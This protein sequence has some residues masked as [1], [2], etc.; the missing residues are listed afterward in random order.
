MPKISIVLPTYNG[1]KWIADAIQSIVNQSFG[2]WELLVIDDGSTDGTY[3]IVLDFCK[4]DS[5][6]LYIKNEQNLGLQ[7]TLNKGINLTKGEYIARIDDDDRWSDADKLKKQVEFLDLNSDCVLIG[8]GVVVVDDFDRE[9]L[10][11]LNPETDK[12]IRSTILKR[13]PFVH[14]SVVFRKDAGIKAGLYDE[15]DYGKHI[16]DYEFWF[17]LGREGKMYNLPIYAVRFMSR[18]GNTTN[19]NRS[20]QLFKAIR[21][22]KDNRKYY[23]G[24]LKSLCFAYFRFF[25]FK[26]F[27]L[28][29]KN[30][31]NFI[32]KT[33]K[34]T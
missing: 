33:Y 34:T 26:I 18:T 4:N 17:R 6:V 5:R 30:I 15:G 31:R 13:N 24:Y 32:F 22:I 16:E 23:K 2:D 12:N 21:L 19:K 1:S 27:N 25:S 28:L 7:K 29:P 20:L 14:S 8:T 9:I 3:K 11:Y 10:R